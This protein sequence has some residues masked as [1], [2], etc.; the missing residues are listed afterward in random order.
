MNDLSL[1][2]FAGRDIRVVTK[3]GEPWF[4][5][6]DVCEILEHTNPSIAVERLEPD[7][8]AKLDPKLYLGS[9]SNQDIWVVNE[10]GLYNLIFTSNKL[11][12]KTFR[13]WV[14]SEVLPS[15]RKIG[16]YEAPKKLTAR[17]KS[18]QV[19]NQFT[20]TLAKHG[21]NAPKHFINLTYVH[22]AELG[23]PRAKKKEFYDNQELLLTI[24]AEAVTL[25]NVEAKKLNGYHAIKPE[26]MVSARGVY[27]ATIGRIETQSLF[28]QELEEMKI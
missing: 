22:K 18:R 4:V 25:H 17:E 28:V 23:I 27:D 1:F 6:K 20:D 9:R 24:A 15:I 13:K 8:K 26:A 11:E 16:S 12:A 21:C 3:N 14:T 7:E 19:R 10:S 2:H 5:A